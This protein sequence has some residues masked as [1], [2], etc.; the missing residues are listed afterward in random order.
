MNS[1]GGVGADGTYGKQARWC[2]Y[3][4]KRRGRGNL[5]EGIAV[6]DL[7]VCGSLSDVRVLP[8]VS[9]ER[10]VDQSQ[11][12]DGRDGQCGSDYWLPAACF[13]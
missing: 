1:E 4:G 9:F 2:G 3:H 13:S 5:V 12:K 10:E 6:R 7:A 11:S 8:F